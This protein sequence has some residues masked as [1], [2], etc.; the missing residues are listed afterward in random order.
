MKREWQATNMVT[1]IL[2][3]YSFYLFILFIYLFFLFTYLFIYLFFYHSFIHYCCCSYYYYYDYYYYYHYCYYYDVQRFYTFSHMWSTSWLLMSWGLPVLTAWQQHGH[4]RKRKFQN[5]NPNV[6]LI[7]RNPYGFLLY[8][9]D[10]LM[11]LQN[12]LSGSLRLCCI[13]IN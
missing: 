3:I 7:S 12:S 4:H 13:K 1:Q 10:E 9:N 2:F 6:L 5:S 8:L 11:N